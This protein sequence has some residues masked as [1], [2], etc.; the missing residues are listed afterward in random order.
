MRVPLQSQEDVD[1]ILREGEK[2]ARYGQ[3]NTRDT[4]SPFK[5]PPSLRARHQLT[6]QVLNYLTEVEIL[7]FHAMSD[8]TEWRRLEEIRKIAISQIKEDTGSWIHIQF[9]IG[10]QIVQVIEIWEDDVP[11]NTPRP[12]TRVERAIE[13]AMDTLVVRRLVAKPPT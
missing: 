1:A 12:K 9:K 13:M 4:M 11:D 5:N 7:K 8:I 6:R 10:Q 3:T 2:R